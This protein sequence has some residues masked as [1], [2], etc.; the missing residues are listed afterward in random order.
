MPRVRFR[1]PIE[2][3]VS[4][5]AVK[6]GQALGELFASVQKSDVPGAVL[7][8]VKATKEAVKSR[9]KR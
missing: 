5:A 2:V 1:L 8:A 6:A 3:D 4:D 9:S 7:R